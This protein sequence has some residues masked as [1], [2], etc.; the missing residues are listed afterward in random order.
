MGVDRGNAD[1]R[2]ATKRLLFFL[3]QA[4]PRWLLDGCFCRQWSTRYCPHRVMFRLALRA[5]G[6]ERKAG[7]GCADIQSEVGRG[8]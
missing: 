5:A 1:G 2:R 7:T 6:S 3:S 8:K 4:S